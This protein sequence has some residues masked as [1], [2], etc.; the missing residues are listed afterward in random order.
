[1]AGASG[2]VLIIDD[3]PANLAVLGRMLADA[4]FEV[5]VALSGGDAVET[6]SF[7]APDLILL[8]IMMPDMDGYET[9]RRLRRMAS[10]A[11]VPVIFMTALSDIEHKVRAFQEGAVDYITKPF[12]S[13]EVL[14][15]VSTH[16][17]LK[18]HRE[19]LEEE[20]RERS[21]QLELINFALVSALESANAWRDNDSAAHIRRVG[22][23]S[24]LIAEA[25]GL[26]PPVVG[27][28]SSYATIHD[29]GKIAVPDR[30]LKKPGPL[31]PEEFAIMKEHCVAGSAMLANPGVPDRARI[32]VRSHHEK[33][34]GLGYPDG[35]RGEAIPLE[36]RIVP[37]ADVYDALRT[38]RVYKEAFDPEKAAR[39]IV[40]GSGSH[41]DPAVVKAF[42]LRRRDFE[43]VAINVP[44]L[45][46]DA[47]RGSGG[48][49]H[50]G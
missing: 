15:R 26:P 20:V 14:Q 40:D 13:I 43:E 36:A 42:R 5:R 34:N 7:A 8:D 45:E 19:R 48:P 31:T 23:Y 47:D 25:L 27:E 49:N 29:I 18:R 2:S 41:F 3:E 9:M 44:D 4:D 6:A 35:L 1:M 21:H 24:G 38:K 16:V 17:E 39:I 10:T 37:I 12:E 50:N 46:E 28:I 30:I 22:I 11:Q 32:I 33:W